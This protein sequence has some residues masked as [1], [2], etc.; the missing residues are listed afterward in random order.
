M[1][2]IDSMKII[3]TKIISSKFQKPSRF[4]QVENLIRQDLRDL[5]DTAQRSLETPLFGSPKA[6]PWEQWE[7]VRH[8]NKLTYYCASGLPIFSSD[9]LLL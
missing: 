3:S 7:P 5:P 6:A 8:N 1:A 4:S 9:L 2:Q